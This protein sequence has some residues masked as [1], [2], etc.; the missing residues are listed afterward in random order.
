MIFMPGVPS[1][2]TDKTNTGP[3]P[4]PVLIMMWIVISNFNEHATVLILKNKLHL[5]MN[6]NCIAHVKYKSSAPL[7]FARY[8]LFTSLYIVGFAILITPPLLTP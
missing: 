1:K 5:M 6:N 3:D 8:M 2:T 4:D 7:F